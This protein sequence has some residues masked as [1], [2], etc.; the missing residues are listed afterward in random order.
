MPLAGL[1]P[2]SLERAN[3]V[4]LDFDLQ[5]LSEDSGASSDR[6]GF[7]IIVLTSDL[8]G[9]ELSFWEDEVWAQNSSFAHGEGTLFN[10]TNALTSYSLQILGSG[11]S[12]VADR[13]LLSGL[14][15][16]YSGNNVSI[17]GVPI[18]GI[19]NH[20]FIG[21]DT[22][23]AQ[24]NV[25]LGGVTLTTAVVPLPPSIALALVA[26]AATLSVRR[27]RAA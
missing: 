25:I 26:F 15:R 11:Y 19:A 21:D 9:A 5:V 7:S 20:T 10:T 6:S 18:Y 12:L 23:S 16:D 2:P 27:N 4:K 13:F 8:Q 22:Q 24:G 1:F 17:L 3:A 14:L